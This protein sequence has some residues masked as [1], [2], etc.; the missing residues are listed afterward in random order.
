MSVSTRPVAATHPGEF[1]PH[2]I[3]ENG[4]CRVRLLD[5]L[6]RNLGMQFRQQHS[7]AGG[8]IEAVQQLPRN[9]E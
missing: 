5:P 3:T 8:V 9:P 1:L 6:G 4:A 7:P 2:R